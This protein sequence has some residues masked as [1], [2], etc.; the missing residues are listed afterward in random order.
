[1]NFRCQ[2]SRTLDDEHRANLELMGRVEQAFARAPRGSAMAFAE[3]VPLLA[4]LAREV[5]QD[6][7]RHFAF[8]ER[9]LFPLLEAAGQGDLV[10][11][12]GEEHLAIR[13]VAA[14][15][16]PLARAAVAGTL[17]AAGWD[18]LKRL[19]GELVERLVAHI[20]KETMALLPMLDDLLDDETDRGLSFAYA[21]A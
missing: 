4:T 19:A 5:E 20:E 13:E 1:M 12:L 7:A 21:E 18:A 17:N 10:G 15:L 11:L 6:I 2:V 14:E 16:L 3:L 8:E 9:E